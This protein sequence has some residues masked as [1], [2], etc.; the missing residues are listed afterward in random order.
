MNEKRRR[1][2]ELFI[3]RFFHHNNQINQLRELFG[4]EIIE[5]K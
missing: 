4:I 5:L 3:V 2:K 1:K